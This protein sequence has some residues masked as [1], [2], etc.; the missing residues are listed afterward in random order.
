MNDVSEQLTLRDGTNL[1]VKKRYTKE[2]TNKWLI[3]THGVGEHCDRHQYLNE[4]FDQKYNILQYDLRGH[5][6]S[7]GKRAYIED[8]YT[9]MQDLSEVVNHV[10][11]TYEGSEY[12]LFAHSMGALIN[13]GY[14]QKFVDSEY[15]PKKVFLSAPPIGLP[16]LL[17]DV[18]N[19]L[20]TSVVN[21]LGSMPV[22]VALKGLADINYLSHNESVKIDYNQ[23]ELTILKLHTKL[24]LQLLKASR[25]VF[26]HPLNLKCPSYCAIG[27]E[28][29]IVGFN[30]VKNYFETVERQTNFK[31]I[32]GGYHEL[33]NEIEL[34]K[35]PYFAYLTES[36]TL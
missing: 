1:Y 22:T 29:G 25:E 8:F 4:L 33:H 36:L 5:G 20:P 15:Y 24:V 21:A 32:E 13:S 19:V 30:Y 12:C 34:Y 9:F 10:K 23:D 27:S 17:G 3:C 16:G 7:E 14:L 18:Y 28:D 11:N 2:K 31:V 6:R 35:K 26:L